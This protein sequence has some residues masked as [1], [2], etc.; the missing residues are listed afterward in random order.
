MRTQKTSRCFP[1]PSSATGSMR[2]MT[3][4]GSG[5]KGK[6]WKSPP[7]NRRIL[8]SS[9]NKHLH[10][11]N[12]LCIIMSSVMWCQSNVLRPSASLSLFLFIISQRLV[13]LMYFMSHHNP[14][15]SAKRFQF[16]HNGNNLIHHLLHGLPNL[17][18]FNIQKNT[19]ILVEVAHYQ[20]FSTTKIP[21]WWMTSHNHLTYFS[22]KNFLFYF[23][24]C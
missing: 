2:S 24:L 14:G 6:P 20:T 7:R 11:I 22:Q 8:C 13:Q 4:P 9:D 12:V 17:T 5:S 15:I 1:A 18:L 19:L 21:M 16:F 10:W 3:D 23:F